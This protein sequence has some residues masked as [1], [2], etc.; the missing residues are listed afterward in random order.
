MSFSTVSYTSRL[1]YH[2]RSLLQNMW[3]LKHHLNDLLPKE[4]NY[5]LQPIPLLKINEFTS[6]YDEGLHLFLNEESFDLQF[7]R[8]MIVF[9]S[10]ALLIKYKYLHSLRY[11]CK[12]L[13]ALIRTI[14]NLF[15]SLAK[16][17]PFKVLL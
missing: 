12:A 2:S 15:L 17:P 10:S 1:R 6:S 3:M 7:S 9:Y 11:T 8:A 4:L 16:N 13:T 14:G 5:H